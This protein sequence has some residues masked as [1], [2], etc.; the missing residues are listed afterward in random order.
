L[1]IPF[2]CISF[3][4]SRFVFL[5]FCSACWEYGILLWLHLWL[6]ASVEVAPPRTYLTGV[7]VVH[8]VKS[9]KCQLSKKFT[10]V[11]AVFPYPAT[12]EATHT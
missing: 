12:A 4:T 11:H 2:I 1:N 3:C 10:L 8:S 9:G 7:V 5:K 6:K